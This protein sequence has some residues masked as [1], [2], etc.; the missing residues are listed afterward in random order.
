MQ[1]CQICGNED[2]NTL[3]S[4][5]EMMLGLREKFEYLQCSQCGCLQLQD[6]PED[7]SKYY[8]PKYYSFAASPDGPIKQ[9]LKRKRAEKALGR[10][11][12]VGSLLIRRWGPPPFAEW[13][14]PASANWND[15]ILDVGSGSG[16]VLLDM[17][18]AGFSNLTGIDPYIQAGVTFGPRARILKRHLHELDGTFDL[19]LMSHSF[20]HMEDPAAALHETARLLRPGRFLVVRVPVAGTYAWHEYGTDWVQLDAPRH[21]FLHTEN[22]IRRLADQAGFTL[23]DV[24]Y[25]SS[26]FQF[27]ASEQ[28]RQDIPLHDERS[29]GVNPSRSSFTRAQIAAY[30]RKAAELNARGDGDQ[31]CF[32]LVRN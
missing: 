4:A 23:R 12:L 27:W 30:E 11:S 9:W 1:P 6:P 15:A 32:Y 7:W 28:Y 25:D 18:Q 3:F 17:M 19:V 8:P 21:I 20:E 13:L 14:K 10:H 22:S 26:S 5:R 16:Q 29:Y 31:A 24:R 2:S